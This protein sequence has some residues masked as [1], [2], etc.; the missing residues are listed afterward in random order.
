MLDSSQWA[1]SVV[2]LMSYNMRV[3]TRCV[4]Y[5]VVQLLLD[6][7]PD[8]S[9]FEE[10]VQLDHLHDLLLRSAQLVKVESCAVECREN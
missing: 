5:L 2:G 8:F 1:S 7:L 3:S 10:W 4:T 9:V 6:V